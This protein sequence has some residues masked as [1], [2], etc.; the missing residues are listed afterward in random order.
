MSLP[1]HNLIGSGSSRALALDADEPSALRLTAK[2]RAHVKIA[3][4]LF[5]LIILFGRFD[6]FGFIKI[7]LSNRVERGFDL[8]RR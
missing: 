4:I 8:E 5:R 3:A 1:T 2:S 6:L 7:F